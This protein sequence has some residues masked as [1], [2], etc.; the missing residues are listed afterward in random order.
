MRP[1]VAGGSPFRPRVA[2]MRVRVLALLTAL[3]AVLPSGAAWADDLVIYDDTAATQISQLDRIVEAADAAYSGVA[4]LRVTPTYWHTPFLRLAA[5]RTDFRPYA[6]LSFQIRSTD[7]ELD[8]SIVAIDHARGSQ[9]RIADYVEGGRVDETWRE[10]RIP[11]AD[12]ASAAF[13]LESVFLIG[14]GPMGAPRPFEIDQ[15]VLHDETRPLLLGWEALSNRVIAL[16]FDRLL[17]DSIASA[18]A[19]SVVSETDPVYASPRLP[20][21]IG[22]SRSAVEIPDPGFSV[23]SES[24]LYLLLAEPLQP[25]HVYR[26]SLAGARAPSGL[27]M[28]APELTLTYAEPPVS[29]SIKVNQVGYAPSATKIAF[30]GNWLGDLGPMP[31]DAQTF[32][33]VDA[34]TGEQVY[35]GELR[36]RMAADP[37]S[38]E[39]VHTAD[40]SDLSTPGTW[41][42]RVPG[43][44][45]SHPFEI[46]DDVYDEVYRATMR[47]FYHKRNTSLTAPFADPGYERDGIDP[48]LNALLHP[49]LAEYPLTRGETPFEFKPISGGWYDA[50][51]Y[52]Q[53]IHNAAPVWG[54][55]GLAWDLA[56]PGQ[57]SDGELGIPESGNGIPDLIDELGWGM[58]WALSMQDTDGGVYWRVT[59]ASWDWDMPG[60]LIEPRYIYEKTTRAT[61]QF[62]AMGAIYSRLIRPYDPERADTLLDAARRAWSH[63]NSHPFWPPE[64]VLYQNP[65]ELSGGGTYAVKSAKPEL[66]WAAAELY[67]VTGETSYQDAVR[68]L[69]AQSPIDLT[70]APFTTFPLWALLMAEHDSRDVLLL[71]QARRGLAVAAD[72]KLERAEGSAYRSP[73]HPYIPYT[74]W[75]N[76]AASP[77]WSVALLQGHYLTGHPI[78]LDLAWQVVDIMLGANPLSRTWLTGI[79]ANPV[80][81]PLDRISLSD[82]MDAPLRGLPVPGPTW[83]L[84]AFRE[85]YISVNA[86]YHPPAQ[87]LTDGDW[88]SAYPVLR[89]YTDSHHLIPMNESTVREMSAVAV[90]FGLLRD[91]RFALPVRDPW[92]DWTPGGGEGATITCLNDIPVTDVP[93]LTPAQIAAFGP[94][95]VL[96]TQD[97]LAVLTD[98]Q[99]AAL[100]APSTPYWVAKLTSLQRLALSAEQISAFAHW[101]LFT[102]LPASLVPLIPTGKIPSLGNEVANTSDAWKAAITPEQYEAMTDAQRALMARAGF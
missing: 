13:G 8:P 94:G 16:R 18:E 5:G 81:D 42:V 37:S 9:L 49:I 66:L 30:I 17:H 45:Q 86:A 10:A 19:F 26:L 40:F 47:V 24:L 80:T 31:V 3:F 76:F 52:G 43:I 38:G 11:V 96:A 41:R 101:S 60:D 7:G 28:Q 6:S 64:G 51:D 32:Q 91:A 33:I 4:G 15:I 89:R 25:G 59:P 69:L 27:G 58:E 36:L 14:F 34:R 53:Y 1:R 50:G 71:E 20:I 62:A 72:M 83:H 57:F 85:P 75:S 21:G 61:A 79:G 95:A 12:L 56:A 90:G 67:R 23:R 46:A 73:K 74:G 70:G 87:P 100:D 68:R 55:F 78:Y 39:D 88:Q 2:R 93:F 29:R 65:P 22:S 97:R 98:A 63:A 102:T 35:Q 54:L 48:G 77:M 82:D 44:G 84:P 92:Y 99:V